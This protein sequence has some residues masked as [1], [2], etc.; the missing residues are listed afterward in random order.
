LIGRVTQ[1][2]LWYMSGA[3]H[4]MNAVRRLIGRPAVRAR[5]Y[6]REV[7]VGAYTDH[8][9]FAVST[10]P[11]ELGI[12]EFEGGAVCV[13]QFPHHRYRGNHWEVVGTDGAILG[14]ELVLF[15]GGQRQ[16]YPFRREVDESGDTPAL[17]RVYVE[18]DPP[19]V[20][21]NHLREYPIGAGADEIAR[22]DVFWD[23]R[24]AILEGGEP[25]YG[26]PNARTDQELVIA[27]RESALR[28]GEWVALPLKRETEV[29]RRLHE[30]YRRRYGHAPLAPAEEAIRTLYP[31]P[32]PGRAPAPAVGASG[33]AARR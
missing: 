13:Y 21:E 12:V 25:G 5:G 20:W 22:A 26:A 10:H 29:E 6:G 2:H 11:Y 4:G 23:T 3:Y 24:R 9:G 17:A 19:V 33:P 16:S 7:E 27:V 15:K 18:T 32:S 30:E 31:R 8:H 1:V 14:D 28:D